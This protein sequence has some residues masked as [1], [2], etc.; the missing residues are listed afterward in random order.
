MNK[1]LL[2]P[3]I[4]VLVACAAPKIDPIANLMNKAIENKETPGGVVL[5][6]LRGKTVYHKAFGNSM[7]SPRQIPAVKDG[8][9]DLTSLTKLYTATLIMMLHDKDKLDIAKPV[10]TYLPA[11]SRPDKA[12][13][14]IEQL[15]THCSGLPIIIPTENFTQGLAKAVDNIAKAALVSTP[16]TEYLYS[17]LGYVTAS[18]L[19]EQVTGKPF[20][21]LLKEY[22]FAPLGLHSTLFTPPATKLDT[23]APTNTDDGELLHGVPWS[24][25]TRAL[26]GIGGHSGLFA[27]AAD[28]ATFGLLFLN[29]GVV[30]GKRLLSHKSVMMMTTVRDTMPP[31][32]RRAI[33]FDFNTDSAFA[34]GTVF[35]E[36]SFG[37]T[38]VAGTSLWIDKKLET[39]VVILCNRSHVNITGKLK[40]LRSDIAT[41]AAKVVTWH[42]AHPSTGKISQN[43]HFNIY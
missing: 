20:D 28:V 40:Q 39:L 29:D 8:L 16:G 14:T 19:A 23:I 2:A 5:V 1:Y 4:F 17:D 24:P 34:R 18:F 21:A 7:V 10:A 26:G 33:G 32:K 3:L 36:D 38:G 37:H 22:I 31:G 30:N 27:S 41:V 15:L 13:I 11:F 43:L 25:R 42:R 6:N 9:Y 12:T 35:D